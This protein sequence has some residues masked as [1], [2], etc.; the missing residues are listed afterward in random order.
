MKPLLW[1]FAKLTGRK[2]VYLQDFDGEITLATARVTPFG[3]V[4]KRMGPLD[5]KQC[6]CLSDGTCNHPYVDRWKPST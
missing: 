3:L 4:A 1:L 6:I 2:L 5:E